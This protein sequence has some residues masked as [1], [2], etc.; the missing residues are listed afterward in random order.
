MSEG[1]IP[2]VTM[3]IEKFIEVTKGKYQLANKF[4]EDLT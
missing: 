3:N 4:I 1:L 2:E